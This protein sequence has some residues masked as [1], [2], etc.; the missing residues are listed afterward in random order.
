MKKIKIIAEIGINHNGDLNIA[1]KLIDISKKAG[2]DC[3]KFQKRTIDIVYP[4][5]VL[6]TK[7]ES[8]WGSTT[9]EQKK[10]L[11][12]GIKEYGIID[13]YCKDLNIDWFASAW[14]IESLNFLEK[15]N[16][17]YHKIASAMI[18]DKKFV[19]A[20]AGLKKH[21]FISTGMSSLE[22][23][24]FCVDTFRKFNTSFELMHCVSL[25]P[26]PSEFINL[27]TIHELKKIFNCDVGYSGHEPGL[28]ISIAAS[29]MGIT[30]L[31][32]HV[33]LDRS[34][35]GSDQSASLEPRGLNELIG[36]VRKIEIALGKPLP[37]YIYEQEKDIAKKLRLHINN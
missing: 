14:D 23:I 7:R 18:V 19:E 37:G 6:D 8:P 5:S 31:E 13:Q 24:K 4:R 11:E 28:A 9:E 17:N 32:R 16:T 27:R 12:F 26:C 36:S 2:V 35:Y 30:S 34:M 33:T 25:Y 10:G 15:F 3:V 1:K 29:A 22:D 20:V 21:T